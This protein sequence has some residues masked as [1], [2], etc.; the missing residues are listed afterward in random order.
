MIATLV[1]WLAG[2][3]VS[4]ETLAPVQESVILGTLTSGGN[5]ASWAADDQNERKICEF[6]RPDGRSPIIQVNL[7]FQAANPTAT[8]LDF[9]LKVNTHTV[10]VG[11]VT[12]K[13]YEW[14]TGVYRDTSVVESPLLL[15]TTYVGTAVGDPGAYV[16]QNGRVR[17]QIR[18]F[19]RGIR[20]MSY[21]CVGFESANV[22]LTH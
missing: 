17:G 13:L 19:S 2:L 1:C 16:Q 12:I 3:P 7:E 21:P 18:I 5:L 8:A 20:A 15:N 22:D 14:A 11:T 9:N 6:F 4:D 10:G